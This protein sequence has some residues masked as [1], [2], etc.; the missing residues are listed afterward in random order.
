MEVKSRHLLG[1]PAGLLRGRARPS[2]EG[3]EKRKG[4]RPNHRVSPI[5]LPSSLP[6]T[7]Q[8]DKAINGQSHTY[9][10]EHSSPFNL[11]S[12]FHRQSILR[13]LDDSSERF[14]MGISHFRNIGP[15]PIVYRCFFGPRKLRD[16]RKARIFAHIKS[17]NGLPDPSPYV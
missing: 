3:G 1:L 6:T 14:G 4:D 13:V 15:E 5:E 2:E 7:L 10:Y 17:S 8:V 16:D 12:T 9:H 11:L